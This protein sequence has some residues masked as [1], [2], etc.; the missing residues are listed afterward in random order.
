M[1]IDGKELMITPAPF[2]VAMRLQKALADA[3][4]ADGINLDLKG[5]DINDDD[6]MKSEISG[7]TIGSLVENILAVATS[8]AVIDVLFECCESVAFGQGRDKP[9]ADFFEEVANREYF[10]PIMSEVLKVNL[11]PFFKR[12]VSMFGGLQGL[13]GN[14]RP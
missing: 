14:I 1:N 10:Y 6:P 4:R 2:A 7:Q 11:G 13:I 5:L 3:L 9:N 12:I 8:P